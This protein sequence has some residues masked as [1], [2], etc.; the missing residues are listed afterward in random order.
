MFGNA[1]CKCNEDGYV[2]RSNLVLR[3]QTETHTQAGLT[4]NGCSTDAG[5]TNP[6]GKYC[7]DYGLR[8]EEVVCNPTHGGA[9]AGLRFWKRYSNQAFKW[10][11]RVTID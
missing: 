11:L 10:S 2:R 3:T 7:R 8:L 5:C 1:E 6:A 4:C 9:V